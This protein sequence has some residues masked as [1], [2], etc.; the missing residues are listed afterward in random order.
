MIQR[1]EIIVMLMGIGLMVFLFTNR[2]QLAYLPHRTVLFAAYMSLLAGWF[3]TN[4][5]ALVW[6]QLTNVAEH[7]CYAASAVLMAV[8]C[9]L[10]LRR[11]RAS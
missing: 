7:L 1:S 2:R 10:L 4:L 11:G 3:L 8:W 9:G 5:E 6:E